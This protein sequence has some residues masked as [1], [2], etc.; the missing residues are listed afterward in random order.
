MISNIN[1]IISSI[2]SMKKSRYNVLII[3]I[4]LYT[5]LVRGLI[6]DS[7]VIKSLLIKSG[8]LYTI[9]YVNYLTNR[10]RNEIFR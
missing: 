6:K 1:I 3:I 5:L 9:I 7:K 2:I 8:E 10:A 4:L